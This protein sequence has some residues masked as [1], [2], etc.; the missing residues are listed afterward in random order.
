MMLI[1]EEG[2]W[3][4]DEKPMS[5]GH[6]PNLNLDVVTHTSSLDFIEV[7]IIGGEY[8]SSYVSSLKNRS[9]NSQRNSFLSWL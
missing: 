8:V 7:D 6:G 4:G 1:G 9:I 2:R 3:R 5:Q